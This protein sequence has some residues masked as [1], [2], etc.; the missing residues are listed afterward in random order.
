MN[1]GNW[2][3]SGG[4]NYQ[5]DASN[6]L[7]SETNIKQ[8]KFIYGILIFLVFLLALYSFIRW[9]KSDINKR[10]LFVE[11][12]IA[13]NQNATIT[14]ELKQ[15]K[16]LVIKDHV[17]LKNNKKVYL[18]ELEYIKAEG[19]YLE[20]HTNAK[21]EVVRGSITDIL[22]QLP[23]NFVQTHRS[24][25]VNKNYVSLVNISE[26][27]MQNKTTIPLSRKYKGNFL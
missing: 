21:N 6:N 20:V 12:Q 14:E 17:L 13:E 22:A 9:K 15:V 4:A 18:N 7:N 23:P 16:Q 26:I 10:K 19:H 2:Q 5:Y 11:K 27:V 24:F 25:I 1:N 3:L 8:T